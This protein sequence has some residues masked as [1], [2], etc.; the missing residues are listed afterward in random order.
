VLGFDHPRSGERLRF[1][2]PLPQDLARVLAECER[3]EART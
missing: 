1:E 2:A 3:R